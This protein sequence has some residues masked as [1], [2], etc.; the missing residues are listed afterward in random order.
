MGKVVVGAGLRL[1]RAEPFDYLYW[2]TG[3]MDGFSGVE[4]GPATFERTGRGYRVHGF[5]FL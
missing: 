3:A 5:Y 4:K 2:H 1:S